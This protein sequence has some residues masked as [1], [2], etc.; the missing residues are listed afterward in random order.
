MK[1]YL[2]AIIVIGVVALG[3]WYYSHDDEVDTPTFVPTPP[4]T[5]QAE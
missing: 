5:T 1:N 3:G 2:I 4:T